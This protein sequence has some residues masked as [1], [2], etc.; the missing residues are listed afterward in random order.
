MAR[1]GRSKYLDKRCF[2]VTTTCL[3]WLPLLRDEAAKE[4]CYESLEFCCDRFRM[5]LAAYVLMPNHMHLVVRFRADNKLSEFMRDFKKFT[6]RKIRAWLEQEDPRLA[7]RLHSYSRNREFRLWTNRFD[8][9]HLFSTEVTGT[10]VRY[11][12]ANPVTAG[13]CENPEE[14]QHSS[15][16]WYINKAP[17]RLPLLDYHNLFI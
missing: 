6:S 2:F 5:D 14:Y 15:A 7:Y 13:L 3:E 17:A 4:V 16:Q 8:D 1:R 11:I 9:L 10:K 12:H